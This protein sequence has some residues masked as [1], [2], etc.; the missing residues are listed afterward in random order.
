M[1]RIFLPEERQIFYLLDRMQRSPR[2]M[3]ILE[4]F[5][6]TGSVGKA[7][8][9]NGYDS[10]VSVDIDEKSGADY[11]CDVRNLPYKQLATPDFIWASPPC[12]TYS[13]AAAWYRHRDGDG[14]AR[15]DDARDAD[16]I[17]RHTFKII[18]HFLKLN[19]ALCFC[20][21][22]PRGY[23]RKASEVQGLLRATTTYNNFGFP[24]QKATDFF[25]NFPLA[26]PAPR[27]LVTDL[28]ITGSSTAE[29]RKRMNVKTGDN[30]T[31]L[32]YRIPAQLV[33]SILR[34]ARDSRP[35]R[36]NARRS[37]GISRSP[38][39][40]G[41]NRRN[42]ERSGARRPLR[43]P[44]YGCCQTHRPRSPTRASTCRSW[45]GSSGRSE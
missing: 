31:K 12:T 18:R 23:M 32:L 27:R 3:R 38:E 30:L 10:V 9:R 34:Q 44:T 16:D 22:N 36:A 24:Y 28:P 37:R 6:G 11:V 5:S 39:V 45:G 19:S 17:L 33:G 13:I 14:V 7:A 4:L 15:T 42:F 2:A 41:P 20:V 29:I 21:E 25:T 1:C 43:L 35:K 8:R 40:D 26:L